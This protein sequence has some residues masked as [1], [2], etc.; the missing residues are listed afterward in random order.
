M[1]RFNF[2][3]M[4]APPHAPFKSDGSLNL[5][6]IPTYARHLKKHGITAIWLNGTAGE[7]MSMTVSERKQIAEAWM[8]CRDEISTVIVQ[9][10][11]GSFKNTCELV[12]HAVSIGVEGVALLPNLFDRPKTPDELVDFME[13]VSKVCPN[14]PLF[15]YHIPMKTC[16]DISMSEFLEKGIK[17]IPNLAGLKFTDMDVAGEGK[18]CLQVAGGTLTIFNGFDEKLQEAVSLGFSSAV[19][20]TFSGFPT[21]ASQIFSFMKES[22]VAEAK[23]VQEELVTQIG[24]VFK[25]SGGGFTVA[26]LKAATTL[27]TG[28]DMGPTRFPVKPCTP[29]MLDRLRED[30]RAVGLSVH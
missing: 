30:L 18:K 22:K 17:R 19:G 15:Y 4:M 13:E 7:G 26:H 23:R 12:K 1:K 3:G 20:G 25:Q 27:L 29:A 8:K 2:T 16:V 11:A 10:E 24:A 14:T 5:D 9:C 21:M 6:V 28:I